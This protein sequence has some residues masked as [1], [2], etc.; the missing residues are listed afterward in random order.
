MNLD[1]LGEDTDPASAFKYVDI[2][3]VDSSG[4]ISPPEEL[5]TFD[6][7]PSR[8]RRLAQPGDVAISTVRTYLRAI[9]SVPRSEEPLVFSTGFAILAAR[10][11]VD[12]R[13]LAYACREEGFIQEVEAR[14]TGVSYPAISPSELASIP[15][16]MPPL[17]EQRRI[18]DFLDDQVARIDAAV[19]LRLSQVAA[20]TEYEASA[21]DTL[22]WGGHDSRRCTQPM[23][24]VAREIVV[25]IVVQP[26]SYYTD[27]EA[28]IPAVRGTDISPAHV[29]M[30]DLV[31]ISEEGH[32]LHPR[33]RLQDGDLLVVRTGLAGAAAVVPPELVGANTI[34]NVIARPKA[35]VSSHFLEMVINSRTSQL[36]IEQ[37]SVGAMQQHFGVGAMKGLPVPIAS[38]AEQAHIVQNVREVRNSVGAILNDQRSFNARLSEYKRSLITAAVTGELD[39]TTASRGVPA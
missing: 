38:E 5:V 39:V 13:F 25:G 21:I 23:R 1:T 4:L 29:D 11:G 20:V 2:S 7:A 16:H 36:R 22:V 18:A 15:I 37:E 19:G 10:S 3:S 33:S 28:G 8:A 12:G 17:E 6:N 32:R 35:G 14:S 30:T 27:N 24:S 31:K 34:S 9:A 26:A